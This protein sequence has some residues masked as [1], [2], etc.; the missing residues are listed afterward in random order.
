MKMFK[1]EDGGIHRVSSNYSIVGDIQVI[2]MY[3]RKD[4]ASDKFVD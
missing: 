2:Y 1:E 4:L 3:T